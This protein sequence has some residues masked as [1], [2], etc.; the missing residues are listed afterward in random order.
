MMETALGWWK[1]SECVHAVGFDIGAWRT[2]RMILTDF[3]P[4]TTT[5]CKGFEP[6]L[7]IL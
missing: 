5:I 3:Q 7:F 6:L 1:R 4:D 2:R